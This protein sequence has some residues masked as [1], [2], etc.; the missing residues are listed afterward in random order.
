M[1]QCAGE[2]ELEATLDQQLYHHGDTIAVNV[3]IRNN[4]NKAVKKI[5]AAVL[6]CIDIAMFGGGNC[7]VRV[8]N[9]ETSEGCP[10]EPGSSLQKVKLPTEFFVS[11]VCT[12]IL[13]NRFPLYE[14]KVIK[15]YPTLKGMK[16]KEGIALDGRIRGKDREA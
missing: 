7:K 12:T 9:M 11:Y 16:S 8:A 1:D 4:S 2:L 14:I 5:A 13:A 6:Q 15:L 10:V 3:S